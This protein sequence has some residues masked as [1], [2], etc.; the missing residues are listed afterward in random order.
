MHQEQSRSTVT[1]EK[2]VEKRSDDTDDGFEM[3]GSSAQVLSDNVE[4]LQ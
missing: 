3:C 4:L 2:A 1:F